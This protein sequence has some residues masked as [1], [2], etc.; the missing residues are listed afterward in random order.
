MRIL[1]RNRE[2][3]GRYS[4]NMSVQVGHGKIFYRHEPS[5]RT[6]VQEDNLYERVREATGRYSVVGKL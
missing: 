2:N 5:G 6:R 4:I 1:N 3:T